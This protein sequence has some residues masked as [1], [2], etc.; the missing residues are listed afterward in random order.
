MGITIE[1]SALWPSAQTAPHRY[2]FDQSRVVI[3]RGRG[4]D[5]QLPHPAVSN[6]HA[7]IDSR[8]GTYQVTDSASTNGT[9]VNDELLTSGRPQSLRDGDTI[10][11]GGFRL[12]VRIGTPIGLQ[13]SS[14]ETAAIARQL[15]RD[16]MSESG[17]DLERAQLLVLNGPAENSVY[18]LAPAPSVTML[19]RSESC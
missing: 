12:V 16:L 5:V 11:I 9:R 4:T 10:D 3:G 19:G 8:E 6:V 13:T 17:N 18:K 14:N 1:L 7:T 15:I 2:D